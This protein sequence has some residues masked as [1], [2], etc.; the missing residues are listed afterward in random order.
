M[1]L[2]LKI[3]EDFGLVDERSFCRVSFTFFML[4]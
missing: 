4:E 2:R 3:K 1:S